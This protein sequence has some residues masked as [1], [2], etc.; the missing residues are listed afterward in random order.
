MT[1]AAV[2]TAHLVALP[3]AVLISVL[4]TLVT[5]SHRGTDIQLRDTFF[6][7]AHFHVTAALAVSALVASLVAYRYGAINAAIVTAWV[8][9]V[10][11]LASVAVPGM[12]SLYVST[13][14]TTLVALVVGMVLSLRSGIYREGRSW[15]A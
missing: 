1:R 10:V 7:V 4:V 2:V 3:V 12:G 5:P 15:R 6:V 11:H 8:A 9:L 14:L 13:T